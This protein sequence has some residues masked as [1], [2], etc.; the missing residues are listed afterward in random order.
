[1]PQDSGL[2]AAACGWPLNPRAEVLGWGRDSF[3]SLPPVMTLLQDE[4][5]AFNFDQETVINPETGEQVRAA[6]V[7]PQGAGLGMAG[8]AAAPKPASWA[9]SPRFRAGTGAGRPGTASSA[10][11]PLAMK[12]AGLKAWASTSAS[13][14]KC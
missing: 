11:S 4:K 6:S 7:E 5:G 10:P 2:E 13:T 14:P 3:P 12:N 9:S 8:G 1:M